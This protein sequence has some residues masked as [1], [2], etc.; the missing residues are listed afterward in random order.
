MVLGPSDDPRRGILSTHLHTDGSLADILYHPGRR[1][2]A[3]ACRDEV[4]EQKLHKVVDERPRGLQ[5]RGARA[6]RTRCREALAANELTAGDVT[7][8]IA[9]QAN[10]RILDAT[11]DRLEIP[12]SRSA[13]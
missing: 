1:L 7:H 6:R 4:L 8:V 2:A 12:A 9:H 13:G 11:L 3:P 5:V 10:M